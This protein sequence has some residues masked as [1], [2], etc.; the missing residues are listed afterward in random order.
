MKYSANLVCKINVYRG[1]AKGYRNYLSPGLKNLVQQ[2]CLNLRKCYCFA[3]KTFAF[4]LL[5]KTT[6]EK[7]RHFFACRLFRKLQRLSVAFFA[8]VAK[9]CR[10]AFCIINF[11]TKG[12]KTFQRTRIFSRINMTWTAALKFHCSSKAANHRKLCLWRKRKGTVVFKKNGRA[13]C[14]TQGR[15]MVSHK[16]NFRIISL[17]PVAA[18]P[19]LGRF[20]NKTVS[21][22]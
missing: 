21:L 10:V 19:F 8:D 17:L 9:V 18:I 6:E 5:C 4:K 20:H 15:L 1:A 12:L 3:V 11:I 22:I 14:K 16:I 13:C 7:Q 2:L